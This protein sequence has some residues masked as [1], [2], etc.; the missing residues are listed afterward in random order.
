MSSLTDYDNLIKDVFFYFSKKIAELHEL[1]VDDIII[2][3]GFGF[4]KTLDQNYELMAALRGFSMFELPLLVGVSR[5]R[6]IS[7]LLD[8]T[9][10]E[11]LNGT[12]VL[13]AFAIENGADILRVHDVKE[14]VE[15]IKIIKKLEEYKF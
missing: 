1:G 6:M 14:A 4:S 7:R 9:S 11:S 3:P 5:K 15:A 13:N 10:E 2:D 12:S 8:I